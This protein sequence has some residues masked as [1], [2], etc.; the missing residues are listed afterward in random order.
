MINELYLFVY[1]YNHYKNELPLINGIQIKNRKTR[2]IESGKSIFAKNL[3]FVSKLENFF[4]KHLYKI[5]KLNVNM[6]KIEI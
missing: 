5:K 3:I 2:Q 4:P 6:N 1:F